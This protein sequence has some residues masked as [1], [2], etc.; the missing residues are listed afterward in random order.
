M[1]DA[2]DILHCRSGSPRPYKLTRTYMPYRMVDGGQDRALTPRLDPRIFP[3]VSFKDMN[4]K[5]RISTTIY[6]EH[7]T[8]FGAKPIPTG[9]Y[10]SE[11]THVHSSLDSG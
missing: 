8:V 3:G 1:I 6:R 9:S 4:L 10:R 2:R 7:T 11:H 5:L